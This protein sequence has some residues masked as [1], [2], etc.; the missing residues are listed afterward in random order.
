MIVSQQSQKKEFLC[1][2]D[3]AKI[4]DIHTSTATKYLELLCI[5]KFLSKEQLLDKPGKPT[6]YKSN[7][8]TI[9][10]TLDLP[11]LTQSLQELSDTSSLPNPLI[12][13]MAN[14]EPQVKYRF[15]ENG[16]ITS[17][18]IRKKTRAKRFVKQKITLSKNESNFMKY[19]P[20]PT[21]QAEPFLDICK[22]ANIKEFFTVKGMNSFLEKLEKYEIIEK[23]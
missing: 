7:T 11:H 6:Y 13:E 22:K 10:I 15:D 1:A 4:L 8:Q 14:L 3:I 5:N 9:S 12:R 17:F 16:I 19:L 18:E 2:L 20:H 21:M 23:I